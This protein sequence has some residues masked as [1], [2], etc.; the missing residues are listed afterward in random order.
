M[1][2]VSDVYC[3]RAV[4]VEGLLA[5]LLLVLVLPGVRQVDRDAAGHLDV[6]LGRLAHPASMP[7]AG[8]LVTA[9]APEARGT[10][11]LVDDLFDPATLGRRA[12]PLGVGVA[13]PARVSAV[14]ASGLAG[15][16]PCGVAPHLVL[17]FF[18]LWGFSVPARPCDGPG[19]VSGS[20]LR[21]ATERSSRGR[22]RT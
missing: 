3:I 19:V 21:S 16:P 6:A 15:H 14:D 17:H 11:L 13:L 1:P 9:H 22:S 8:E 20:G 4:G 10:G 7:P 2:F 5:S 12:V 18:L